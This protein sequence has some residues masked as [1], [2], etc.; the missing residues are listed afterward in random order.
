MDKL[1]LETAGAE[2]VIDNSNV[3]PEYFDHVKK[4]NDVYAEQISLSDQKAAYIFTFMLAFLVSSAEGREVFN[5][6]HYLKASPLG[7]LFSAMLAISSVVSMLAAIMVVLPQHIKKST[8]LF[9]GTWPMHRPNFEAAARSQ[10][11]NYLFQQYLDNADILSLICRKKYRNVNY[12][13][14]ALVV[15]VISYVLLLVVI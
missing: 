9:W 13:F 10:D 14:R 11:R 8:S 2:P 12:A 3:S 6:A 4:I 5:W 15:T 7:I 1:K